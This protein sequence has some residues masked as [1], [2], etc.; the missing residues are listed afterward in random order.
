MTE[1]DGRDSLYPQVAKAFRHTAWAIM[2]SKLEEMAELI[3]ARQAGVR[4]SRAEIE[5][6]VGGRE[7]RRDLSMAGTVA[8]VPVYGVISGR[9]DM[10]TDISGGT[11]VQ[12]LQATL[13]E[14][15]ADGDV[16]A[17]VLDVDSPGGST[18][19]L[20]ELART[21]REARGTKPLVAVANTRA[22]SAAYWLASQADELAVTPSGDVGSIGVYAV[23]SDLSGLY[24]KAGVKNTLISAGDHK[25]EGHPYVPLTEEAEANIQATIDEFYEMFVEDVAL[26]RRVSASTVL[27]SYGGGRMLTARQALTAGMVDSIETLEQ[28]VA[29]HARGTAAPQSTPSSGGMGVATSTTALLW[30]GEGVVAGHGLSLSAEALALQDRAQRLVGRLASLAEVRRGDLTAAKREAL[31]ACP[32]ELRT[33]AT[34][35]DEVLAATQAEE[36]GTEPVLGLDAEAEYVAHRARLTNHRPEE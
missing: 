8:V 2:P 25:T 34:R 31:Q 11:S 21:I 16:S 4:Y 36:P 24:E 35:L 29:R 12:R 27:E 30:D 9:A 19:L 22:A 18:D 33:V 14:V 6:R 28:V 13:E 5:A 32:G 20:P 23:H 15:L 10:M 3:Q 26:G 17:V 1:H 7:G